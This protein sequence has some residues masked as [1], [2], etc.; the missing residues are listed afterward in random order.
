[1]KNLLLGIL[2]FFI[3]Q[4]LVWI[5]TNGQFVWPWIKKNPI[6]VS[7]IGG[8][9]IS[10][11]FIQATKYVVEYY[12]GQLWPGRFIGFST[13]IL[14]FTILTYFIMDEGI[15]TKTLISLGLA[16]ALICVQLFWK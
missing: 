6:L 4:S 9:V 10:Y 13:G 12:D 2:L 15:N 1:L 16:T 11:T 7:F 14:A 8:T 3:G 5:Q